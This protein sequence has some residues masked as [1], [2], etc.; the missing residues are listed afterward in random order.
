[1]EQLLIDFDSELAAGVW[2]AGGLVSVHVFQR[3]RVGGLR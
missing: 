2:A 3:V 1:M